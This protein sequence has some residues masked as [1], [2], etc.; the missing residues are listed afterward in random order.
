MVVI[1]VVVGAAVIGLCIWLITDGF[2]DFYVWGKKNPHKFCEKCGKRVKLVEDSY[3]N[4]RPHEYGHGHHY[5]CP[6]CGHKQYVQ[7]YTYE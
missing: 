4:A 3:E 5:E 7:C 1:D 6:K 2:N